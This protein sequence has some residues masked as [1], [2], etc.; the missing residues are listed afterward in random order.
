MK[1]E[2]A[3]HQ[4]GMEDAGEGFRPDFWQGHTG[5][6]AI[7]A[8]FRILQD[9]G[10]TGTVD[11]LRQEAIEHGWFDP[12]TGTA[13]ADIG[14]LLEL[15]GVPCTMYFEANRYNLLDEL[16]QGKRVIVTVDSDELWHKNTVLEKAWENMKDM[17][18][19][20]TDHAVVVSGI[21]TADPDNI[22]VVLTDSGD[23]HRTISYPIDQFE[24]A[25]RDGNCQMIVTQD[26]PPEE[27]RFGAMTNGVPSIWDM[28]HFNYA[29]GHVA[30]I[31]EHTFDE[32]RN[33]HADMLGGDGTI[34]VGAEGAEDLLAG[35]AASEVSPAD[36]E[37]DF[38]PVECG[39]LPSGALPDDGPTLASWAD[40]GL[41]N[42]EA[43]GFPAEG[44][45]DV[46]VDPV[47]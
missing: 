39:D 18:F 8:Q 23:G 41:G 36:F 21:N 34:P 9:Y 44:A 16:A 20:G 38:L 17:F 7:H 10:Y 35:L 31:G 26:P 45:G 12:D 14:K 1:Y 19:D 29:A 13:R 2:Y 5:E 40:D 47:L 25:W 42:G 30:N 6:C 32:W 33:L 4:H 27:L 11:M 43:S 28:T 22:Q 3:S 24:N 37:A 15:H 46:P